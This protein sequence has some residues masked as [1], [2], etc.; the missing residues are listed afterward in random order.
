MS[1]AHHTRPRAPC[2]CANPASTVARTD[3]GSES[4]DAPW[5]DGLPRNFG[6]DGPEPEPAPLQ[7]D[8]VLESGQTLLDRFVGSCRVELHSL[9]RSELNG[10]C[11]VIVDAPPPPHERV[12]VKLD[13]DTPPIMIKPRNII[14]LP[15]EEYNSDCNNSADEGAPATPPPP[16]WEARACDQCLRCGL[17]GHWARDCKEKMCGNCGERGHFAADCPKQAPCFRCGKLGH[18]AKSCPEPRVC[19]PVC[20]SPSVNTETR[21]V[22]F[23][24]PTLKTYR[25]FC[26]ICGYETSVVTKASGGMPRHKSDGEWCPGSGCQPAHS[27]LL[28]E[29]RQRSGITEYALGA[30]DEILDWKVGRRDVV[31]KKWCW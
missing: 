22:I 4:S 17:F 25:H 21:W 30:Y 20:P 7:L 16:R 5:D 6:D 24:P 3:A 10:R 18:W 13:G 2:P 9:Q 15:P 8:K 23:E 27:E 31:H 11:G 26:S 28:S 14:I 1:C 12:P 19:P 29:R